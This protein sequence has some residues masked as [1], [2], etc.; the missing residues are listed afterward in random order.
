MDFKIRMAAQRDLEEIFA[1]ERSVAEAPH[2]SRGDYTAMVQPAATGGVHR[3]LLIA[4][5]VNAQQERFVAGFAVGK[6]IEMS[7]GSVGELESV[8][9]AEDARRIGIGRALC[10]GVL[11][12]CRD[13]G[14]DAVE[15]ESRALNTSAR[16]LYAALGFVEEGL[17]KG[18][19]RDPAD[20]AVL[21]RFG[22]GDR[23]LSQA[24]DRTEE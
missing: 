13:Q 10:C 18:Y 4:E 24:L 23:S 5:A 22:F 6:V 2:W 16:K 14:A 7:E 8:V 12:W 1:L 11:D 9:V 17:R 20:D 3:R 15:L 19:Y 21:M